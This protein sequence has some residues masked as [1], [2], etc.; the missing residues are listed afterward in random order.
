[1]CCIMS[2]Y[3]SARRTDGHLKWAPGGA[4]EVMHL[5]VQNRREWMR[6]EAGGV[7]SPWHMGLRA[8]VCCIGD[9]TLWNWANI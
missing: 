6:D 9:A 5:H 2:S 7:A 8:S 1:M 4:K 3:V